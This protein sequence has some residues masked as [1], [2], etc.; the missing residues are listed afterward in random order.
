MYII[1][2][3]GGSIGTRGYFDD[4]L[5]LLQDI[6]LELGCDHPRAYVEE[7]ISNGKAGLAT[8]RLRR[9]ANQRQAEA[10]R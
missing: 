1:H 5:R 8:T 2:D 6:G 3:M 4:G 7:R 10:D 9:T